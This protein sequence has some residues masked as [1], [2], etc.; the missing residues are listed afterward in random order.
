MC[1]CVCTLLR[2]QNPMCAC[3]GCLLYTVYHQRLGLIDYC[4]V[5]IMP[6]VRQ[7]TFITDPTQPSDL[8]YT[9]VSFQMLGDVFI[10]GGDDIRVLE[11]SW[12]A[13][14]FNEAEGW[15]MNSR[16]P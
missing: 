10:V 13:R 14:S 1:V 2:V 11:H 12:H 7:I 9:P 3:Y 16:H 8:I 5:I 15:E 6:P 4:S